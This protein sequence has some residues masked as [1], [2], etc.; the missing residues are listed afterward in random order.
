M[1]LLVLLMRLRLGWVRRRRGRRGGALWIPV[2]LTVIG[3]TVPGM[4]VVE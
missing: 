3:G 2:W 1:A 4:T